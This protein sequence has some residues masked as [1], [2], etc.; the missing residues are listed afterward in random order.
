MKK[1]LIEGE[2]GDFAAFLAT[3][4]SVWGCGRTLA[5]AVGNLVLHDIDYL[6]K[7]EKF[8]I[9]LEFEKNATPA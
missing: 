4:D 9:Q 5:E 7:A 6:H 3:D 8:E 1:I 2:E